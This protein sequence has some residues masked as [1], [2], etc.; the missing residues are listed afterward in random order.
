MSHAKSQQAGSTAQTASQHPASLQYGVSR[1]SQHEP[2]HSSPHSLTQPQAFSSRA[3]ETQLRSQSVSQQNGSFAQ[4]ASQHSALSH[5]GLPFAS[6][7]RPAVQSPHSGGV[8]SGLPFGRLHPAAGSPVARATQ[9]SSQLASQQ[10]GSTAQ[11]AAQQ[12]RS[13][14]AGIW[15]GTKHDPEPGM[16]HR[17]RQR[18]FAAAAQEESQRFPQ[19]N[20][21]MAQTAS[22]HAGSLQ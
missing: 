14:Q 18:M 15:W 2:A 22:Q 12:F 5:R 3:S 6:Q 19:Q 20:G 7:Q 11:T 17:P 13:E 10:S 1:A 8:Q 16:P 21:S 4:T 9:Q